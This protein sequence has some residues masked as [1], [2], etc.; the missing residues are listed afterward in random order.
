MTD[1]NIAETPMVEAEALATLDLIE[2]SDIEPDAPCS[3]WGLAGAESF[4]N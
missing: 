2:S 3:V 1:D 4:L